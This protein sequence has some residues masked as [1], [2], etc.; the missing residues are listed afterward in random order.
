MSHIQRK[1][2]GRTDLNG[3]HQRRIRR[4]HI[5]FNEGFDAGI[6]D[7]SEDPGLMRGKYDRGPDGKRRM[8]RAYLAAWWDGVHDAWSK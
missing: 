4:K 3:P 1:V 7:L 6:S 5:A 2:G 8:K